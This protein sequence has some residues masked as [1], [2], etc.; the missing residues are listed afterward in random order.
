M[1]PMVML[2][3]AV[4]L[5]IGCSQDSS[6][7]RDRTG[8]FLEGTL[9]QP[10]AAETTGSGTTSG[11]TGSIE[12]EIIVRVEG[13]T[14]VV[15]SGFC[16]AGGEE[17]VIG[18]KV[19]K[20]YRFDLNGEDLSCRIQKRDPGTGSLRVILL[21]GDNTRSVQQTRSQDSIIKLSYKGDL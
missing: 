11:R 6:T 17:S 1:K 3:V 13:D 7:S 18:G 12:P 14:K 19:P 10:E 21:A 9:S 16:T 5:A 15:F 2:S 20:L 4:I 8:D